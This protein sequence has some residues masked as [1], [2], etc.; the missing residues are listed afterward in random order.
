MAN[1]W[2]YES[3]ESHNARKAQAWTDQAKQDAWEWLGRQS[4]LDSGASEEAVRPISRG[5]ML[6]T[7]QGWEWKPEDSNQIEPEDKKTGGKGVFGSVLGTLDDVSSTVFGGEV[8]QPWDVLRPVQ[9]AFEAES[10]YIARPIAKAVLSPLGDYESLPGIVRAGA[11]VVFDPLTYVGPGTVTAAFK[12]ARGLSTASKL[13]AP[14]LETLFT[15]Q[16]SKRALAHVVEQAGYGLAAVGGGTAFEELG[17]PGAVG[18][19]AAP[20]AIGGL[21]GKIPGRTPAGGR[22]YVAQPDFADP[23]PTSSGLKSKFA[24]AQDYSRK[25]GERSIGDFTSFARNDTELLANYHGGNVYE[26]SVKRRG[27]GGTGELPYE[28]RAQGSDVKSLIE[29]G[30]VMNDLIDNNPDAHFFAA[31]TDARRSR[32][33]QQLGFKPKADVQN[34]DPVLNYVTHE[35]SGHLILDKEVFKTTMDKVITGSRGPTMSMVGEQ[36]DLQKALKAEEADLEAYFN[37]PAEQ[38]AK[39]QSDLDTNVALSAT[40]RGR[41]IMAKQTRGEDLTGKDFEDIGKLTQQYRNPACE[42]S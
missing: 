14:S 40:P 3:K 6:E 16:A 19:M 18:S 23:M 22:D 20:F 41:E 4:Q 15:S 10:K 24:Y 17:L 2:E 9:R 36:P 1:F 34:I 37:Q 8:R 32:I 7:P 35:N 27:A 25:E 26:L 39:M 30:T 12:G 21:V 11:E 5:S 33:Y 42:E 28:G 38:R 31:P 13:A 29:V